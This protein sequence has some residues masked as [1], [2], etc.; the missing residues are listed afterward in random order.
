M[1]KQPGDLLLELLPATALGDQIAFAELYR[2][3]SAKFY[4]IATRM[5]GSPDAVPQR[6]TCSILSS[7]NYNTG[8]CQAAEW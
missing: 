7:A 1:S 6:N 3:T 2:I 4:A 5:L 8:T